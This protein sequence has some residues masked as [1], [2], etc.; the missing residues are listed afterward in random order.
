LNMSYITERI[1]DAVTGG[2]Q[3]SITIFFKEMYLQLTEKMAWILGFCVLLMMISNLDMTRF[4]AFVWW[5]FTC[6]CTWL[7]TQWSN[8][9]VTQTFPQPLQARIE[10]LQAEKTELMEALTNSLNSWYHTAETEAHYWSKI[11]K[12]N[13][14]LRSL[15]PSPKCNATPG[16]HMWWCSGIIICVFIAMVMYANKEPANTAGF[17]SNSTNHSQVVNEPAVILAPNYLESG[18]TNWNMTECHRRK[19][20][21]FTR[22]PLIVT[23]GMAAHAINLD[24]YAKYLLHCFRGW[25]KAL[26]ATNGLDKALN[27]TNGLDKAS[28]AT[29]PGNATNGPAQEGFI[30]MSI[31]FIVFFLIFIWMIKSRNDP[32]A[33]PAVSASSVCSDSASSGSPSLAPPA[34][35]GSA[36]YGSAISG[37]A[38]S[39]SAPAAALAAAPAAA[40]IPTGGR[41]INLCSGLTLQGKP[42]KKTVLLPGGRCGVAHRHYS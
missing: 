27:A 11:E 14:E 42:C 23:N 29:N 10:L 30:F 17:I 7:C 38:I 2:I 9:T 19:G 8:I 1:S 4:V 41:S 5:L 35:A 12:I 32:A 34:P 26:N 6:L 3:S 31:C 24:C 13:A 18:H 25:E 37:S 22:C 28:N 39:G 40:P 15:I 20:L 33:A 36:N 21:N 16:R